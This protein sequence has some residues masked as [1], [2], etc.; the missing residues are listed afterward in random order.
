MRCNIIK[1]EIITYHFEVTTKLF[2]FFNQS[3][4]IFHVIF[5]QNR[6]LGKGFFIACQSIFNVFNKSFHD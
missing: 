5:N 4:N 6:D 2:T 3:S 1:S